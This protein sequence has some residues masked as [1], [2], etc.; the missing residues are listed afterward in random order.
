MV[1]SR[2]ASPMIGGRDNP[3][4]FGG[5]PLRALLGVGLFACLL[6]SVQACRSGRPLLDPATASSPTAAWPTPDATC[7]V[8]HPGLPNLV[9]FGPGLLSGGVPGGEPAFRML[10]AH[11]VT[12]IVSVDGAMPDVDEARKR[13]IA[14]V[15]L[16]IGYDD[17]PDERRLE[18]TRAV[19]DATRAGTVYIHCHHGR[20]RSAAA[21]GVVAIGLGWMDRDEARARMRIAGTSVR[22]DGLHR[23][24]DR[25]VVVNDEDLDRVGPDFPER[26]HPADFVEAMVEME[27]AMEGLRHI[28]NAGWSTPVDH[29]DLVPAAEAGRLADLLRTTAEGERARSEPDPEFRAWLERTSGMVSAVEA[30]LL[31]ESPNPEGLDGQWTSIEASCRACHARYRD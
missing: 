9:A 24:V 30:T 18:L 15:H 12:T 3:G 8:D 27:M 6:G 13:G 25:A 22:Y 5:W 26:H 11:G 4:S 20:H 7:A 2:Y 19:R 31:E 10:A 1:R 21:A 16:P 14:T 17:I 28:A 23:A 29:P